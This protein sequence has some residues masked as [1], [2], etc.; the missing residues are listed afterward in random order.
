MLLTFFIFLFFLHKHP[1]TN[2]NDSTPAYPWVISSNPL[3]FREGRSKANAENSKKIHCRNLTA[4]L[5][6]LYTSGIHILYTNI[7]VETCT[8]CPNL[9][10][11]SIAVKT[12]CCKRTFSFRKLKSKSIYHLY[13]RYTTDRCKNVKCRFNIQ[14]SLIQV[15]M[16]EQQ[17]N[18]CTEYSPYTLVY[19]IYTAIQ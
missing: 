14:G 9:N 6:K 18:T 8:G 17:I 13:T 11:R 2:H 5:L 16:Q 4:V 7:H 19:T 12:Y 10:C 15:K 1:W 3:M